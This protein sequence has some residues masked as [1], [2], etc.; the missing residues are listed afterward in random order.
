[1]T[2]HFLV[3]LCIAGDPDVRIADIAAR[4][5]LTERGVQGIVHDLVEVG[6]L[7]RSRVGRRNHY[8]VNR[9]MP[10]RHLETQHRQLG[11]LLALLA[12]G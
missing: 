4:L 9:K 11:D 3:L 10:L 2:N 5:A 6:Y 12:S 8:Q 7:T 1:M